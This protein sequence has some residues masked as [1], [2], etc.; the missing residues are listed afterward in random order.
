MSPHGRHQIAI[1][2]QISIMYN[3]LISTNSSYFLIWL[4]TYSMEERTGEINVHRDILKVELRTL[5]E[6][7]HR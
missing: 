1:L 2:L 7:K 6:E 5:N 3:F 4:F